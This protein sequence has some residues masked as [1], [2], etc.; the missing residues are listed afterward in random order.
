MQLCAYMAF[1][2]EDKTQ[3]AIAK[4]STLFFSAL[5]KY[6][7]I[8]SHTLYEA[9]ISWIEES[10][11]NLYGGLGTVKATDGALSKS[12]KYMALIIPINSFYFPLLVLYSNF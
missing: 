1:D 9:G 3:A 4:A 11:V 8:I 12:R 7:L 6:K 5:N 10:K 2:I